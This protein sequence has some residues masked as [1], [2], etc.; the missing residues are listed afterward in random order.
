VTGEDGATANQIVSM[1]DQ[2]LYAMRASTM[3]VSRIDDR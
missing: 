2:R 1:A 3:S